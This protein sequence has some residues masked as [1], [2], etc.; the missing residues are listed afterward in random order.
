[1]RQRQVG[2]SRL[3][4]SR[5]GLGTMSWGED[6]DLDAAAERLTAFVDA[7]GTLVETSGSYAGGVAQNML[8]G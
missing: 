2:S 7:G 5:I 8:A 4:I 3:R 6:T 1:M